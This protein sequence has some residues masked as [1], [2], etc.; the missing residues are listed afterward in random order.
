MKSSR[1]YLLR[2]LHEWIVD[3]DCTPYLL[4]DSEHTECHVPAGYDKDGQLILNIAPRAVRDFLVDNEGLSFEGRFAGVPR[5]LFV[6]MS[7]VLAI[8][9]KEN[10]QGMA[11]TDELEEPEHTEPSPPTS[12]KVISKPHLTVVK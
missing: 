8:Y 11:F 5:R 6:P 10:G 1:P 4:V 12:P 2:A 3:N 7:A 9:A